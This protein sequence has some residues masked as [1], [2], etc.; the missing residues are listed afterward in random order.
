MSARKQ[1][2]SDV[3]ILGGGP[4]GTT[5]A[6]LLAKRGI[7]ATVV[8]AGN[9]SRPCMGQTLSPALNPLFGQF[10]I[11]LGSSEMQNPLCRGVASV[12]GSDALHR[13]EFFWTPYGNSWHVERPS[14]DRALA[15]LAS[16]AGAKII[17][18]ARVRS[19]CAM[20]RHKWSLEIQSHGVHHNL[21]CDFVVDA[22]GGAAGSALLRTAAPAVYD[23][24]IGITYIGRARAPYPY[25]VV[26]AVDSGWFYSSP[27]PG[28]R[29]TIVLLTD[30]DIYRGNRDQQLQFWRRQFRQA[31]HIRA[32]FPESVESYP[33]RVFSACTTFRNPTRG[34]NWLIVGDA[35]MSF[36]PV[37]GQGI[38]QA[39]AGAL[40]ATSAI[41]KYLRGDATLRSYDAW[42]QHSF[43]RYLSISRSYYLQEQRWRSSL[44]WQRR[45]SA[46]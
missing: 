20:R 22:T 1:L 35:A 36:D 34:R 5:T 28:S 46:A 38:Y 14:F 10:G 9:Y 21:R 6:R 41:E 2:N 44:F 13:N 30:S 18:N 4:A 12:W 42:V 17:C 25:T 40:R 27:L 45:H 29:F 39:L 15:R 31:K 16:E 23:R 3:A 19:F 37:S 24:L 43:T 32:A 11:D 26:E 7:A 8:E 33:Q